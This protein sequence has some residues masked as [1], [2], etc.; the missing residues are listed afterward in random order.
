MDRSVEGSVEEY[1]EEVG[2]NSEDIFKFSRIEIGSNV[3]F[4]R[5]YKN[6]VKLDS[7]HWS[8]ID[9]LVTRF[10]EFYQKHPQKPELFWR[11]SYCS[12]WSDILETDA[13]RDHLVLECKIFPV[14]EKNELIEKS[15]GDMCERIEIYLSKKNVD[16][17]AAPR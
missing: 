6:A 5:V 3:P 2:R 1:F 9:V 8:C 12:Y 10:F 13:M 11:C 16:F 17:G 4:D 7:S 14:I 15:V